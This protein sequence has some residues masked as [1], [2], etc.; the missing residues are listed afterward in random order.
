MDVAVKCRHATTALNLNTREHLCVHSVRTEA[1]QL[2]C[3]SIVHDVAVDTQVAGSLWIE[4]PY[5]HQGMRQHRLEVVL[6]LITEGIVPVF[7]G[8]RILIHDAVN[9]HT[10]SEDVVGNKH[11]KS[12]KLI[13]I[14]CTCAYCYAIIIQIVIPY[15]RILIL[16]IA[17][18]HKILER[19]DACSSEHRVRFCKERKH[20]LTFRWVIKAIETMSHSIGMRTICHI[21]CNPVAILVNTILLFQ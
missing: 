16:S 9:R 14:V 13:L 12:I 7:V 4:F 18:C 6:W 10:S 17:V 3:Q 5:L 8:R 1:C 21:V 20:L 15:G 11:V 2:V 19:I